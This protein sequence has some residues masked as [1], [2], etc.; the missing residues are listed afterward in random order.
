MEKR[1]EK[2]YIGLCIFLG[3]KLDKAQN[4]NGYVNSNHLIES[5]KKYFDEEIFDFV[6]SERYVDIR[7]K[8]DMFTLDL[9]KLILRICID[10]K[11]PLDYTNEVWDKI[12][13]SEYFKAVISLNSYDDLIELAKSGKYNNFSLLPYEMF[14]DINGIN[15]KFEAMLNAY[16]LVLHKS[17]SFVYSE[18]TSGWH[19]TRLFQDKYKDSKLARLLEVRFV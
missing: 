17:V 10:L 3:A 18:D 16:L 8:E 6:E 12:Y 7:I 9:L 14:I 15:R 4:F 5:M 11:D 2:D 13:S 19:F 1:L